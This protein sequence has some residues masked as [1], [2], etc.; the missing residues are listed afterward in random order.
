MSSSF[1]EGF[2]FWPDWLLGFV[3]SPKKADAFLTGRRH[4]IGYI[5]IG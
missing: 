1:E 2:V 5:Y 4:S 3:L